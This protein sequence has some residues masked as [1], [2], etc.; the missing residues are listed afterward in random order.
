MGIRELAMKPLNLK[1]IMELILKTFES[2][3]S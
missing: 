3:E 1:D 2:K